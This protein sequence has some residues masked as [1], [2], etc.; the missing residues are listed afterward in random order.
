MI[1]APGIFAA[2]RMKL[3]A[4]HVQFTDNRRTMVASSNVEINYGG[5]TIN[6]QQAKINVD[7]NE[8]WGTHNVAIKR[9]SDTIDAATFHYKLNSD[10]IE[11][12]SVTVAIR[13]RD[14]ATGNVYMSVSRLYDTADSKTGINGYLTTCDLDDPH[15]FVWAEKFTYTPNQRIV[16]N[17]VFIYSPIGFLPLGYWMPTYVYELGKRNIIYL[18]PQIGQNQ[19]EGWFVRN[20]FDYYYGPDKRGEAYVDYIEKK[21]IGL[22]VNH[23][24]D[25]NPATS[26]NVY[27]YEVPEP[28]HTPN[29]AF[30]WGQD[31][32]IDPNLKL[33]TA[34]SKVD[35][36]SL[37]S[38][39]RE[40]S[41]QNAAS[42]TYQYG[43]E[44]RN[45]SIR[46]T[47]D[48]TNKNQ[49]NQ[50][51]YTSQIG[52]NTEWNLNYL[53]QDTTFARNQTSQIVQNSPIN[54]GIQLQNNLIYTDSRQRGTATSDERLIT[55]TK[56]TKKWTDY[57][58]GVFEF[59]ATAD[60][61]KN[62]FFEQN[63][64]QFDRQPEV[65]FTTNDLIYQPDPSWKFTFRERSVIGRYREFYYLPDAQQERE[66][67]ANRYGAEN[68]AIVDVP[69]LPMNST[70]QLRGDYNQYGY[71]S[72]GDKLFQLKQTHTLKT[73]W[74]SFIQTDVTYKR[75]QSAGNSPFMAFPGEPTVTS[76][77]RGIPSYGNVNE[78][79]E[80]LS[81][82]IDDIS[83]YH[84]SHTYGF[85]WEK[86]KRKDYS[87]EILIR[88]SSV[89]L[90]SVN[91][92]FIFEENRTDRLNKFQPVVS[93]FSITPT[94]NLGL[95]LD[96]Q[97]NLNLGKTERFNATAQF[98]VGDDI[99]E[100]WQFQ[101]VW[102]HDP[103]ESTFKIQ[104]LNAIKHM[105]CRML[106]FGWTRSL[107]EFRFTYTI[108]AFPSDQ[109]GF[110][111]NDNESFKLQGVL[112]DQ[113][114]DRF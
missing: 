27:L 18:V 42:L 68:T 71:D 3:K 47:L 22:G 65:S 74:T 45:F 56:L 14:I 78:I 58:T 90:F 44:T 40:S 48:D 70:L 34:Y 49:T 96:H 24:Y 33:F 11:A 54:G 77:N 112:D 98:F 19:V 43:G 100:Q 109:V 29:Y 88:P 67:I 114:K 55:D 51:T 61:D 110:S 12:E 75:E 82:Y 30:K 17:N 93:N 89:F 84:W 31:V 76:F 62:R 25:L 92:G 94:Q 8:I 59:S 15:Y 69:T 13:P 107:N 5:V 101:S 9:E 50:L 86:N 85:D 35:K 37:N 106:T 4:D 64:F 28:N 6:T 46:N 38:T 91:T 72:L 105:H 103:I 111:S 16:G 23:H 41:N 97:Y 7:T 32:A 39:A 1:C 102:Q 113:A 21:G 79:S 52:S 63:F 53:N 26:G 80:T 36:Y 87:T 10:E 83:K 66:T 20:T 108:E 95:I 60:P 99:S 57:G 2:E 73:V 104:S 81:F